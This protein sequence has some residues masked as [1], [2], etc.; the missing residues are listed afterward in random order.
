MLT[1]LYGRTRSGKGKLVFWFAH[2]LSCN[3]NAANCGINYNLIR[4]TA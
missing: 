4:Q 1:K 2:D 3:Y